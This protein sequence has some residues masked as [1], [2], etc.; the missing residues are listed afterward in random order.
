MNRVEIQPQMFRWARQRSGLDVAT[1]VQRFPSYEEWESGE[2]QPT[3]RQLEGL[4]RKTMTPFGFFFLTEPPEEKLPVPDFRTVANHPVRQASP[5]LLETIYTMQGRQAWVREY[6]TDLGAESLA[7]IGSATLRT[8]LHDTAR[9]IRE[10]LGIVDGWAR[11]HA[12]WGSALVGLRRAIEG[13]GIFVMVNGIVG[14]NTRRKLDPQEFRGFVLC[15]KLAPLIFVNGADFK[16]AQMFTLAHEIAHRWLGRDGVFNL[17]DLQP[18]DN[19]IERLCNAIAA[20][21][22]VPEVELKKVWPLAAR[23]DNP[24]QELARTFKVSP[25]VAIRRALDVGLVSRDAYFKFLRAHEEDEARKAA[26]LKAKGGGGDFY[27][28]QESRLGR[29]FGR[30]V[31]QAA[32]EGKLLIRDAYRLTELSGQTFE[33]FVGGLDMKVGG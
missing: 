5:N 29:R 3:V 24:V 1:L 28:T 17:P 25:L 27:L 19:E 23:S 33:R 2:K 32:R 9:S 14:N 15:D 30:A 26:V 13:A 18:G 6:L 21:V 20:E 16:S 4:S 11:E 10:T 8:D 31:A 7:F 22:L 12:T